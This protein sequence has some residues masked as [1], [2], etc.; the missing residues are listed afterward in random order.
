MRYLGSL[1]LLL[2]IVSSCSVRRFIPKDERIYKGAKIKVTKNPETKTKTKALKSTIKLAAKPT[3]NK[4][5]LGQPYKVWWWYVIG[6]PRH[7]KG[8]RAFL[9]QKLGEPPV[10]A[11]RVNPKSTAENM[12]S[13]MA[14]RGYFFTTVTGD[15]VNT[16]R[17]FTKANYHAYVQPR[18]FLD[19]IEWIKD[20]T[21]LKK[22]LERDFNRRGTLKK[23]DPY[24]LSGITAERERLDLYLKTKGYYFFNPDFLMAYADTTVGSRKVHLYLNIK[25]IT[26]ESARIPYTINE[27]IIFPDYSLTSAH[28]DTS[29]A[30]ALLYD[31][32]LI[33]DPNKK[34]KPRLFKQTITYRPGRLYS[35]R[36]QNTTLNR[37]IN[38]GPFKFIKN[39]FEAI[40]DSSS[41]DI[42]DIGN[43]DIKIDTAHSTPKKDTADILHRLNVYYYL[44]PAKKKSLQAEIDAFTKENSYIGSQV[45]VNWKNR[46]A[47]RGGEQLGVKVYG[48][49]QTSS[50]DSVKNNSFRVGTEVSLKMPRY[51]I[52]FIHLKENFFYPPTTNLLL[53]YEW[54]RQDLYYTKNLFRFQYDFTWKKNLQTEFTLA[55]I[56]LSYLQVTNITDSFYKQTA[57]QPS[58]LTSIYSESTIGSFFSYTYTSG[59][60]SR[61]NK[62]YFNGSA[63][64]SGNLIGLITGA[65]DYRSKKIFGVPFA[66]YAKFDFDLHY[67]RQL[68]SN[69]LSWANRIQIGVGLPYNNSRLLPYAKLYTIGGSSSI[70][71]FRSR[72]LGPGTYKTNAEDQRYF[73][74]IGGD[75][76]LLGNTE[77]RI[78]FTKQLSGAL[79]V[80]AGN[81]WTKDTI[82]FGEQG[83]LTKDFYKDIAVAGGFGIRFDATILLI[84][85]DLGI[86]FR[87][88]YLPSGQRW[89]LDKIAFGNG[90]WRG[91]NLVLNIAIGY[92][93]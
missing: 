36:T 70:R 5:F 3:K 54:Y 21:P 74:L 19:S 32:L 66:Q 78:P 29:K 92:P 90:P 16:G 81:I 30:D 60:R 2:F 55:P 49:F 33:K 18:Y 39:R 77:L 65:K 43:F 12:E 50:T 11:S 80:D 76:K 63:D 45:S 52:P 28:V 44:T 37:L 42:K 62:W 79:F 82:L 15:T 89:V 17:Y 59:N 26:P 35:S 53:G 9:R 85:L 25:K 83:K 75:Y 56:S 14:N 24:T 20:S 71:G 58:L 40:A 64:L 87:K 23:D 57:Q 6:E 93:F 48:G 61:R 86:P 84:R 91:E 68:N 27:I 1:L 67:T 22:L 46:N 31:G 4:F 7:E 47:F 34:F 41:T 10:F 38:L 72:T 73:Q 13:L 8:F 88:P 51:A 69:N